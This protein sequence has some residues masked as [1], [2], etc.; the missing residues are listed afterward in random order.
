MFKYG[1]RVLLLIYAALIIVPLTMVVFTSFKSTQNFYHNPIGI[2]EPFIVDNYVAMFERANMF[3]YFKNSV[4]VTASTIIIVLIL[5]SMIS[6]CIMRLKGWKGNLLYSFFI[7]GMMLPAQ[8]NMIPLY[9]IVSKLGLTN[10]RIG[11]ILVSS[12]AFLSVAV[13]IIGGY[14][15][16][17]SHEMIEASSIDGASEWQIYTRIALPLSAPAMATA[18]IFVFVMVWNDL[19]YPLLFITDNALKTMPLALLDFQGEYLTNYPMIFAGVLIASIPVV[20][21]YLFLQKYFVAGMT[22]GATKG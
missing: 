16:T 15:K 11:L 5:A 18:A 14:M 20:I 10:S 17:L 12:T 22:A 9:G 1:K 6:Y 8:V 19:L 13:Y 7:L 21:A 4:I 2:P 3:T